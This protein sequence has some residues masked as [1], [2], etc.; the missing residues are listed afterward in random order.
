M[1]NAVVVLRAEARSCRL[2]QRYGDALLAASQLPRSAI[3]RNLLPAPA[4]EIR[5]AL[6]AVFADVKSDSDKD[7]KAVAR[8]G[9]AR[10][11]DFKTA[12]LTADK[13]T[14]T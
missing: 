11:E 13:I 14:K 10:L 4:T 9:L 7:L 1:S 12:P 8:Y 5:T 3:A 2:L 6:L